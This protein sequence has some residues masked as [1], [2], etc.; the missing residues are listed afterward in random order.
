MIVIGALKAIAG[1]RWKVSY[2]LRDDLPGE[3][4]QAEQSQSEEDRVRRFMEEFDAEEIPDWDGPEAEP[5]RPGAD[6]GAEAV[7]SNEKGA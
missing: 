5:A 1:G 3:R 7:T 6:S 2:E 4:P